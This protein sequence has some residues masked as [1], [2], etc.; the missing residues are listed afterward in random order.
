MSGNCYSR[1]GKT[2]MPQARA[3]PAGASRWRAGLSGFRT[4]VPATVI[5]VHERSEAIRSQ[6]DFE[7][8]A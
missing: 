8:A 7:Y 3:G 4:T 5:A 6:I 2:L 1:T